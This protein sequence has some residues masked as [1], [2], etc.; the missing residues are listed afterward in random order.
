M[1]EIEAILFHSTNLIIN[2]ENTLI[3]NKKIVIFLIF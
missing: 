2:F 1:V 3:K